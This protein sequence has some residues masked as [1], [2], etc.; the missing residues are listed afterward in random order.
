MPITITTAT[1]PYMLPPS[2]SLALS[3]PQPPS[4]V[5]W[6]QLP[7]S[8]HGFLAE[9]G[10]E[11]FVSNVGT[12]LSRMLTI[13]FFWVFLQCLWFLRFLRFLRFLHF[14][15]QLVGEFETFKDLMKPHHVHVIDVKVIHL[16]ETALHAIWKL[17]IDQFNDFIIPDLLHCSTMWG[18]QS[19]IVILLMPMC[20]VLTNGCQTLSFACSISASKDHSWARCVQRLHWGTICDAHLFHLP[21]L[22][23]CCWNVAGLHP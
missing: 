1:A 18:K 21:A 17:L 3:S 23:L 22:G 2:F 20:K 19:K 9:T 8:K 12:L 5:V 10:N 6:E 11:W 14:L 4:S 15:F 7:W 16:F 13:G